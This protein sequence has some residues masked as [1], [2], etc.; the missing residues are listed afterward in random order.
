MSTAQGPLP[1]P[2][3]GS[4]RGPSP[5]P[6]RPDAALPAASL[7]GSVSAWLQGHW[8]R[9]RPSWLARCLQPVSWVYQALAALDRA[10]QRRQ[11]RR[12]PVPVCV[13]GNLIVGGAGKTP[14][15]IAL[16]QALQ[17][18]GWHPGVVSRG[19]G[20]QVGGMVEVS[21]QTPAASC[22][23][24]PLLIH[25]RTGAPV[26]VGSDRVAAG[27]AL[28]KAHPE[29]NLL[30][31]DDG[32]QHLRLARDR[33]VIVFDGRGAGNG[34]A[35]PAGPLRQ[36][37]PSRVPP[38]SQVLYNADAASTAL[39]GAV[40]RRGLAGPVKLEDWWAG[41]PAEPGAWTSLTGRVVWAAAGLAQPERFF[42][43]LEHQGLAL[44]R[45]PLPDHA[46][47][48]RPPWLQAD[49]DVMVTEKDAVKLRP[50]AQGAA[51]VWVAAL[52]FSLPPVF[53]DDLLAGL[54]APEGRVPVS[55]TLDRPHH[56]G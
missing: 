45:L 22:G 28:L 25:L 40:A 52:D 19:Y 4:S 7:A 11:A 32:L 12:L 9:P 8:W 39:P 36:R 41:R 5:P 56:D 10:R 26:M 42:R 16:V 54:P 46:A 35:L 3:S 20:R 15:V 6:E 1:T 44:R 38:H 17:A 21:R 18:R 53:I 13:V 14:T 43:M 47:L 31:A 55:P 51:R 50:G 49:V 24:E 29:V 48:E 27:L 33:Q 37:L 30:L 23:D 34:L 2:S